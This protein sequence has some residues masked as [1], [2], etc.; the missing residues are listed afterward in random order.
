MPSQPNRADVQIVVR[1]CL[2][3]ID[4]AVQKAEGLQSNRETETSPHLTPIEAESIIAGS[5]IPTHRHGLC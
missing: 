5:A 2:A 3:T 4:G 1:V